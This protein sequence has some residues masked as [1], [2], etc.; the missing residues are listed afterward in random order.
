MPSHDH[1]QS[2]PKLSY[3]APRLVSYGDVRELTRSATTDMNKN[4]SLQGQNNLKT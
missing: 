1:H 4:D 2:S 3:S